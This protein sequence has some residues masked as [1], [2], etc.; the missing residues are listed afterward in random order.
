MGINLL[1]SSE[2]SFQVFLAILVLI[3]SILSIILFFKVWK[4]T[5]N[6]QEILD[7]LKFRIAPDVSTKKTIVNKDTKSENDEDLI[8]K[9][10]EEARQLQLSLLS[11]N[12]ESAE[13]D[14]NLTIEP[15]IERYQKESDKKRL[16]IDFKA[17]SKNLWNE[18]NN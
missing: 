5:N 8:G 7:L 11:S 16:N 1:L 10:Y 18:L 3:V 17:V 13:E 12:K 4:M 9:F 6:V 14:F 15:I 2:D